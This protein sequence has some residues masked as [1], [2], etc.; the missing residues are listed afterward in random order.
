M[1][2]EQMIHGIDISAYQSNYKLNFSDM[3]QNGI[4]FVIIKGGQGTYTADLWN[5]AVAGNVPVKSL[6]F[7]DDPTLST[8]YKMALFNSEVNKYN[9]DF[10]CVDVEQ[11]WTNWTQYF[12]AI[13]GKIPW[14]SV[15]KLT[16][17]QISNSAWS[18][19]NSLKTNFPNKKIVLYTGEWFIRSYALPI[20]KWI[21]VFPLWLANYTVTT[22]KAYSYAEI[23]AQP[24]PARTPLQIANKNHTNPQLKYYYD[25]F[26]AD[27]FVFWQYSSVIIFPGETYNLD[28]NIFNGT[29]DQ[30]KTWCGMTVIPPVEPPV[31]PPIP[32]VEPPVTPPTTGTASIYNTKTIQE[33][34]GRILIMSSDEPK[35]DM[36]TIA[37]ST[38]AVML[39]MGGMDGSNKEMNTMLYWDS[40][41]P[42][43]CEQAAAVGLP[44]LALFNLRAGYHLDKQHM[45]GP[46]DDQKYFDN[47]LI[48]GIV[49]QLRVGPWT[50]DTLTLDNNWR[51]INAVVLYMADTMAKNGEV[52]DTWQSLTLDNV[53]KH[54]KIMQS[55]GR[56][57]NVP[58]IVFSNPEFLAKYK[59]Q[60][61]NYLYGKRLELSVGLSQIV[62]PATP[63]PQLDGIDIFWKTYHP[64]NTFKYTSTPY[65]FGSG[66][67]E[68]NIVFHNFTYDRFSI[69]EIFDSNGIHKTVSAVLWC[70]TKT[71]L[72]K[73]LNFTPVIVVP[74]PTTHTIEERL[75][76]IESWAVTQGYTKP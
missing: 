34:R 45:Y 16:P 25:T 74:P 70:D 18:V 40:A 53:Y 1:E 39:R 69:P 65:G 8:A 68:G 13:A 23:N 4:G 17:D 22:K 27:S 33:N 47:E 19:M 58:I 55:I 57:P 50:F 30:L 51:K 76:S 61:M 56:F 43:R 5:R 49:N 63:G 6:Y 52:P 3:V 44:V 2:D 21:N 14:A 73:F 10:I 31:E 64:E 36:A 20:N 24:D 29:L 48:S 37:K 41:F 11:W 38:D 15:T 54:I 26:S 75:S 46:V 60:L 12:D 42:I 32:P 62:W 35:S 71:E 67:D 72:Y 9:P 28:T 66:K 7:W 59:E